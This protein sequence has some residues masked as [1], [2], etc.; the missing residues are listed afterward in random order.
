MI[1]NCIFWLSIWAFINRSVSQDVRTLTLYELEDYGGMN[2]TYEI[3]ID[4]KACIY[5][6]GLQVR[7]ARL[8]EGVV[9]QLSE[10]V[11]ELFKKNEKLIYS[12]VGDFGMEKSVRRLVS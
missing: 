7:S 3:Y 2:S 5:T 12:M 10:Y 8:P 1:Y 6:S 4:E 9:C 11:P